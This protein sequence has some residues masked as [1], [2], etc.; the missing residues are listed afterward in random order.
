[1]FKITNYDTRKT[2]NDIGLVSLLSIANAITATP[3]PFIKYFIENW[4]NYFLIGMAPNA[5]T[6]GGNY[7]FKVNNRNTKTRC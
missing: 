5:F 1:M 3:S 6:P 4:S 2:P 7:M